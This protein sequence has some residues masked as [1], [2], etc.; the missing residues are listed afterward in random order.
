MPFGAGSRTCIGKHISM[1]EMKQLIYELLRRFNLEL[2]DGLT[3]DSKEWEW[4][5]YWLIKPV[6]LPVKASMRQE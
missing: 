6:S 3:N 2:T 1:L 5:N 4:I